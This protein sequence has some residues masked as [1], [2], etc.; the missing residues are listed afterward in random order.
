MKYEIHLHEVREVFTSKRP[1][2][3]LQYSFPTLDRCN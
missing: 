2:E 3:M 1:E